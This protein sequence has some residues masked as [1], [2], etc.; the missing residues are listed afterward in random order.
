MHP[1]DQDQ[2]W[3]IINGGW[4]HEVFHDMPLTF[5]MAGD[6]PPG[7][8]RPNPRGERFR[9]GRGPG[10]WRPGGWFSSPLLANPQFRKIFL[11]RTRELLETVYTPER[12]KPLIGRMR[13]NL[14][15]EVELRAKIT[16]GDP[17]QDLEFFEH[18]LRGFEQHVELRR[19]FLLAQPEL[20]AR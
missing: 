15:E 11:A 16:G 8:S 3:G 6:V 5:G 4:N 20:A 1:W 17:R 2:T 14:R 7:E 18:C 9:F 10:W 19:R 13:E 12:M